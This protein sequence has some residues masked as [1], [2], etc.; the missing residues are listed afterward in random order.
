MRRDRDA[1]ETALGLGLALWAAIG[2]GLGGLLGLFLSAIRGYPLL[3]TMLGCAIA[4][5]V[6]VWIIAERLATIAADAGAAII[7]P[8]GRTTPARPEYSLADSFVARGRYEEAAAAYES[9]A[10]ADPAAVEPCLRL[11][12]LLRDRLDDPESA[13]TW[14]RRARDGTPDAGLSLLITRELHRLFTGTLGDPQRA[15]PD[16]ARLAER[17]ADTRGGAWARSEIRRLKAEPTSGK[18]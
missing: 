7:I 12:R 4:G 15:L 18:E 9:A 17:H 16:L 8:S 10:A 14:L 3:P 11:G 6:I 13:V 1:Q 2:G 5:A